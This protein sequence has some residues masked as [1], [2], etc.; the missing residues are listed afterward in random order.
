MKKRF[1]RMFF[2]V[3]M[4][5]STGSIHGM[6]DLKTK[7]ENL[8][9]YEKIFIDIYANLVG[10]STE[11]AIKIYTTD[12][13]EFVL[14]PGHDL[15]V[16]LN[17]IKFYLK[18]TKAKEN[19]EEKIK[20]AE[21]KLKDAEKLF[22]SYV[23]QYPCVDHKDVVMTTASKKQSSENP[24]SEELYEEAFVYAYS[25]ILE[26]EAEAVRRAYASCCF[27]TKL[28]LTRHILRDFYEKDPENFMENLKGLY[29]HQMEL[30]KVDLNEYREILNKLYQVSPEFEE[31]DL[32]YWQ[33]RKFVPY[34]ITRAPED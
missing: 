24:L 15:N 27:P 8:A 26:V 17:D 34:S 10:C 3:V 4:F 2:S 30:E 6:F 21:E 12:G 14:H 18:Y 19:H 13:C 32:I 11:D 25:Q 23:A 31:V 28:V 29:E 5:C 1:L 33:G 7:M 16:F 22:E 20:D 9:G